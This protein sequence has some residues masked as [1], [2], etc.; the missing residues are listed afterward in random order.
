MRIVIVSD[1]YG[2]ES[3]FP[4]LPEGDVLIHGGDFQMDGGGAKA[5]QA[6][7]AGSP[8]LYAVK[9]VVRG[10]T[11]TTTPSSGG[12]ARALSRR[13][14]LRVWTHVLVM[15]FFGGAART[16][17]PMPGCDVLLTLSSKFLLDKCYNGENA[18]S[19]TPATPSSRASRHL[20]CGSVA[21]STRLAGT[22]TWRARWRA[23]D[24][25]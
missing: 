8:R 17:S 16:R 3:Q 14:V 22:P 6:L 18:G 25:C 12:V 19:T 13:P 15:F 2:Y 23:E 7:I 11:T 9:I 24:S 1:M 20:S 4:Q 10:I 5:P 21:T